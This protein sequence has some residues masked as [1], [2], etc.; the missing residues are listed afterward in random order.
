MEVK[1][2][3]SISLVLLL[4]LVALVVLY[5]NNSLLKTN[6]APEMNN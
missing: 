4:I 2:H 6:H 3:W 1:K 5:E